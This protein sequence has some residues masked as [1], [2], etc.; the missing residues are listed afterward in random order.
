MRFASRALLPVLMVGSMACSGSSTSPSSGSVL[1]LMMTDAPFQD[2]KAV[3][4]TFNEVSVH[5]SGGDWKTLPFAGNP[6][7]LM[8][9]CDLK[10]LEGNQQDILGT[11]TLAAG[12][13][14]QVRLVVSSATLYFDNPTDPLAPACGDAATFAVPASITSPAPLTVV[15]GEVK[16]TREFDVPP[17]GVTTMV[18]DFKGAQSIFLTGT[19]DYKMTPVITVVSVQ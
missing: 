8:R 12:H 10:K 5:A 3:L 15:S 18:V 17:A 4:V 9:T 1:N 2:A 14:T 13:Y 6:A 19:G 16:L 7:P 11:G